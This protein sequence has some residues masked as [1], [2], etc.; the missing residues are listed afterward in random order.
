MRQPVPQFGGSSPRQQN[1]T[2]LYTIEFWVLSEDLYNSLID[3]DEWKKIIELRRF[4][5]DK[6]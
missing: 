3:N 5:H 6:A 4:H 1:L 2:S